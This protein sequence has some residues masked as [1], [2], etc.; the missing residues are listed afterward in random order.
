MSAKIIKI[1]S[2]ER[3]KPS[4][5]RAL[6]KID[7]IF[8]ATIRLLEQ[9]D[10][11]SLTTNTI[12]E[13]AGVSVG[14]LYQYFEGKQAILHM[15]SQRE[16]DALSQRLLATV[17]LATQRPV[18]ER[19][20][21]IMGAVVET[22]GGRQRAHRR[23]LEHALTRGAGTRLNPLYAAIEEGLTK[24]DGDAP[25]FTPVQAFLFTHAVAGVMR[26]L[27]G[28]PEFNLKRKE[29]EEQLT[30]MLEGFVERIRGK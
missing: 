26:G 13:R 28:M 11:E 19:V 16:I 4:Q 22:Y 6:Q 24:R 15:L 5:E 9:G 14:T 8:E 1:Q 30:L 27:V 23:L 2:P 21:A 29:I 7:L 17:R 25:G 3:R 10:V 12:A 18:R 20:S